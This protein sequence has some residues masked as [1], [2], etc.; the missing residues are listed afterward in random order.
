MRTH[1]H[2][3]R[4]PL[5][6]AAVA[7]AAA[8]LAAAPATTP[9]ARAVD[10]GPVQAGIVVAKV[11]GLAEDFITGVDVSSVLAEEASGVVFRDST[12]A[13]ADLF[14]VLADSGVNYVRVRVWNDPFD[15][16]GHGYGGGSVDVDRAVEIGRRATDA[17]LRVLVDFHYSD[18]WADPAKQ[19]APKAWAALAVADKAAA[20]QDFTAAALQQMQ[21][22][23]VDVGMVQI[24]NETNNAVAGVTGW[25]GMA[26]IFSAGSAAVRDVL[27]DAL[28]AVH[29]TNPETAGR[30]VGYAANLAAYGVDYDVFASSYYPYW[31]G[32]LS[33]LTS[34]LTTVSTT[35]GKKV[36]VA[37]TS[38]AYTLDDGDGHPDV[39][40]S[41]NVT[42]QYPVSV[43]GQATAVR[44]VVAAVAAVGDAGLGVFYWE[45]AWIPVGPAS[46]LAANKALWEQFGSGWASSY[47]GEY[48][49]DDAGEWYGGSAW[50]NQAMFAADG[51]PL[52][53]LN[54]F[55]YVRTGA[56]APRAVVSV[57]DVQVTVADGAPVTLPAT[58]AVTYNDATVEQEAVT[59]SDAV[60]WIE[61]PGTYPVPGTTASGTHLTATVVVTAEN[62]VRNPGFEDTDVSMWNLTG[63][64]AS[65][66]GTG[67]AASGAR[68]L[69]FWAAS[70]Y[71]FGVTQQL[72]G[73]PAGSYT[74]VATAQ[75]GGAGSGDQVL[76][77]AT[78]AHGTTSAPFALTGWR[79]WNSPQ[80]PVEV[81]AD[82]LV[83]V[84]VSAVLTGGAWGTVDD[85]RLV[86]AAG[87]TSDTAVLED[88]VARA[89]AVDRDLWSANSLAD[90]D[91]AVAVAGV[92]LG[93]LAPA[94]ERVDSA[95]ALLADALSGL[96]APG[97]PAPTVTPTVTPTDGPTTGATPT[98]TATAAGPTIEL[99]RAT[100]RPG[101]QVT[102]TVRGLTVPEVEVGVAS[103]YRAL[104]RV[105]VVDGTVT[106]TVTVPGD[107]PAGTHHLQVRTL[108]GTLL[109]QVEI[110]VAA[111]SGGSLASTGA[112]V[113]AAAAL[114]VLLLTAGGVLLA[115]RRRVGHV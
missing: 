14:D 103:T 43:Q 115:A 11:E 87:P 36:L 99:S 18:F 79:V 21:D 66:T 84:G 19:K 17:G 86:R 98:P 70:A 90:L 113:G 30:Y 72:T 114:A 68:A 35:Y 27:P 24:G 81:G 67:D 41:S 64:G 20:V 33:N 15:A 2:P 56:T 34:V 75:G 106:A 22:A 97:G 49:P 73:V 53:S 96:T 71:T 89:A 111:P 77:T 13:P 8:L 74:L 102:I 23:G 94:Q 108:D 57:E 52:E 82:G 42:N 40:N 10:D 78:T 39:I 28:V 92:M 37:E 3:H 62:P 48:D 1:A 29:F 31:H 58:V 60:S 5:R 83:T 69:S 63:T 61:G 45:P 26:Q 54:V 44:D 100:A 93:A 16:A 104:A 105:A 46:Q 7:T 109:A 112:E 59:W 88:L 32:T 76:L 85:V 65:I 25:P 91:E 95:A 12:G 107:L 9:A 6:L 51:T 4:T 55:S 110:V 80:V 50:D 38:W 47:A 101:E